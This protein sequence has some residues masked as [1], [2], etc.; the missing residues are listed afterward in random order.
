MAKKTKKAVAPAADL[1]AEELELVRRSIADMKTHERDLTRTLLRELH[2]E[3]RSEAGNYHIVKADTFKVTVEELALPFALERG[4]TKIDTA[5]VKKVF[6]L[7]TTLR[8]ADPSK[9][10]FEVVTQE[11]IAPRTGSLSDEE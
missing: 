6:Q 4:L 9:F 5:K 11:K 8:F 1:I 3:Q 7:D 10:G 2:E